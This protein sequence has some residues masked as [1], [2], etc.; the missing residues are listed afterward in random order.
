MV[1]TP[2]VPE[3]KTRWRRLLS[4][5]GPGLVTGAADDDPSGIGTYAQVG[6]A[7]GYQLLWVLLFSYP[8]M[9]AVQ[10]ASAQLGRVTGHGLA[11]TLCRTVPRW[12]LL[13]LVFLLVGANLVNIGA[14]LAA[15]AESAST[16]FGGPRLAYA[17][18]M[19]LGSL[20]LQ[21]LV[22][23]DRYVPVLKWLALALLAY[24]AVAL[25]IDVPWL[26][27]L[28]ATF[29][30]S[31]PESATA[32]SSIVAI[33]GTTISPYLFFWQASQEVEEQ[34]N[35]PQDK[36]LK[37]A[38]RQAPRQ[39]E[40]VRAG[41]YAGMAVS[42]L[43]AFF[44]MLAAAATLYDDGVHDIDSAAAAAKALAP[45]AGRFA[46]LLFSIGIVGTGLL[47]LPVLAGSCGYAVADTFGWKASLQHRAA[48]APRFYGTI[49]AVM[50]VG[51]GMN[52]FQFNAMKALYWTAVL[53]GIVAVP[54]LVALLLA[55]SSRKTMGPLPISIPLR[56]FGWI[57]TGIM[58]ACVGVLLYSAGG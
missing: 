49:A 35:D 57:T 6:A 58:A 4:R 53:N 43:I 51:V 5:I 16:L 13:P 11:S 7:H 17:L 36:P 34:R 40:G 22:P 54:V 12:V 27:A 1:A 28:H 2:N 39:M 41:T 30:P 52:F 45:V 55:A 15:M 24:V 21:V 23:Y 25:V 8:L 37:E 50:L 14:D 9:V 33:L 20:A 32:V 48:E 3:K 10:L 46:S 19:G 29:V 26:E 44:I 56:L 42:N 47:A 31:I 18:G 38:P